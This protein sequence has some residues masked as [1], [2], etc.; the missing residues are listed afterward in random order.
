MRPAVQPTIPP[1]SLETS[2][3]FLSLAM[4]FTA[5]VFAFTDSVGWYIS[6]SVISI[7]IWS[8]WH[9]EQWQVFGIFGGVANVLTGLRWLGIAALGIFC[10]QL[11]PYIILVLGILVLVLDGL[12]GYYARKYQTTSI[13]G[14]V[15]DKET[16]A[17]FVLTY[18]VIIVSLGLAGSWVL[19]PGLLRY[20]YVIILAY[21]DK[22]PNPSDYSYRRRFVGMW[23]MGTLLAPFVVPAWMYVPGLIA[24]IA[25]TL[26]S[27]AIDL[28]GSWR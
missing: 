9:R 19:L 4:I 3:K 22:P 11:H 20:G 17:F 25:M 6:L 1:R 2:V 8:G 14:D 26:Y 23:M 15:F 21:I 10:E 5:L 7:L 12:D 27:F 24:A 18:G 16:D 28:R 13:F